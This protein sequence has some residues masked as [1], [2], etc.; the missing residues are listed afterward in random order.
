[1][2]HEI[3]SLKSNEILY[4]NEQHMMIVVKEVT[5][6]VKYEKLKLK[7]HFAEMLTATVSHDMK[8][9]LNAIFGLSNI[10]EQYITDDNGKKFL[11]IIKNSSQIL[12][13]LVNDMLDLFKL[14]NGKFSKIERSVNFKEEIRNHLEIFDF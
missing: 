14:K 10:L 2:Q 1:M 4:Q 13:L 7:N 3:V 11:K 9:P 5:P 8:T 12:Y 6:E